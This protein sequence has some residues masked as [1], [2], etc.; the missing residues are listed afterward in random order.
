MALFVRWDFVVPNDLAVL[1]LQVTDQ[2]NQKSARHRV[3]ERRAP[4]DRF[5]VAQVDF[6]EGFGR[7]G[8]EPVWKTQVRRHRLRQQSLKLSRTAEFERQLFV[9][10]GHLA[11]LITWKARFLVLMLPSL[12]ILTSSEPIRHH[13]GL[14]ST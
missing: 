13:R 5:F 8:L 11:L 14:G 1:D 10:S 7:H 2:R 4:L 6:A 12:R 3:D 9:I